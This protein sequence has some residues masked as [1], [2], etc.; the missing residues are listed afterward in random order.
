[1]APTYLILLLLLLAGS[2][3]LVPSLDTSSEVY[4]ELYYSS[5]LQLSKLAYVLTALTSGFIYVL[6][7]TL[8][9]KRSYSLYS[10]TTL[11]LVTCLVLGSAL[12]FLGPNATLLGLN[13]SP[14]WTDLLLYDFCIWTLAF[15]LGVHWTH[16]DSGELK[17]FVLS[18]EHMKAWS[19]RLWGVFS[20]LI[21]MGLCLGGYQVYLLNSRGVLE[22][23]GV[24]YC[25]ML[26]VMSLAAYCLRTTHYFHLHHYQVFAMLVPLTMSQD[27][28]AAACQG[29]SLG[30]FCE[31]IARWGAA[32]CYQRR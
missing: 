1:M 2:V 14:D 4:R 16:L 8:R 22:F 13:D 21:V 18:W 10:K 3:L 11:D 26:V 20:V 29:F 27:W 23:V 32:N 12:H 31:G 28:V 19:W 6:V 5:K 24:G 25:S 7:V 9:C 15:W 17:K 30:V